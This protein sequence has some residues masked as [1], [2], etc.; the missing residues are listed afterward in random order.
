MVFIDKARRAPSRGR[1]RTR[2]DAMLARA[3][4][5]AG[6]FSPL[7]T[8]N[9]YQKITRSLGF[10][11]TTHR[12]G[13]S[14]SHVG[15]AGAP[16]RR[17]GDEREGGD[18]SVFELPFRGRRMGGCRPDARGGGGRELPRQDRGR[19]ARSPDERRP[20][21]AG[22]GQPG[23]AVALPVGAPQFA[24]RPEGIRLARDRNERVPAALVICV[25]Q[26]EGA[27]LTPHKGGKE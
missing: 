13:N 15:A 2:P 27:L 6:S 21:R 23:D 1:G 10:R 9:C 25:G 7:R 3:K 11:L 14:L 26:I 16:R 12:R 24:A 20:R 4:D 18:L 17:V 5:H 22:G 8:G 19:A